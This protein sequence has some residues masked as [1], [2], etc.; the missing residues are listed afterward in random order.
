MP[1][2][3]VTSPERAAAGGGLTSRSLRMSTTLHLSRDEAAPARARRA[4]QDLGD[5]IDGSTSTNAQLLVSELVTNAV[6]YGVGEDIELILSPNGGGGLRCEVVDGGSGFVPAPR[7]ADRQTGGWG[8]QLVARIADRWGV[9][10]GS[11][12]VWFELGR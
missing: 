7:P 10:R 8:L 5:T 12:H 11:T 1:A 3:R 9:D 6:L 4:V 2:P